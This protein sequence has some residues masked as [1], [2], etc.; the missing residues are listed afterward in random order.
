MNSETLVNKLNS[1]RVVY[2]AL[3]YLLVPLILFRLIWRGFKAPQYWKRWSERFAIYG[4][5]HAQGVIWFHAVSVGEAESVFPL[6]RLILQRH[7]GTR[8]LITTTTPTGSARVKAVMGS[9]V[10]HVYLPYD[11]PGSVERFISHFEPVMAVIMETEI[12][13]N[14]F[15]RCAKEDIPL[16]IVNA[17]I[18]KKSENGYRKIPSLVRPA[19]ADVKVIAAQTRQDAERYITIGAESDRVTVSG[20]LKFDLEI[21]SE[22][23][24]QGESIRN[25]VFPSRPVW[26]AASTHKGEDEMVLQVFAKLKRQVSH[27]LLVLVPRHP[28]RFEEVR[29]LCEA[30]GFNVNMRTRSENC[31]TETDIYLADTMGELK[32]LYAASDV[33]FVGGSLVPVGGHNVIEPAAIGVPIVFGPYMSNFKEIEKGLLD[34]NGAIQCTDSELL[35]Q[36]LEKLLQNKHYRQEIASNAKAFVFKNRGALE[37]IYGALGLDC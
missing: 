29:K 23:V 33:A 12:W 14:L 36:A 19:L 26:I 35:R 16:S 9:S 4:H 1:M 2:S 10:E 34:A 25:T 13:P 32:M 27:L 31:G 17:R 15:A 8:I 5:E 18:S 7:P 21:S 6:V 22:V 28:E 11:L 30:E 37:R 20:N 24:E 3:F